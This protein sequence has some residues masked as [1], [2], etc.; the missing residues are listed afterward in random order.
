MA[1][2]FHVDGFKKEDRQVY[3][4]KYSITQPTDEEGQITGS[5][6]GG[7]LTVRV[8]SADDDNPELFNWMVQRA[9]KAN[10]SVKFEKDTGEAGDQ[11]VISFENA[12]CV[13]YT[14][15]FEKG[16]KEA[17]YEEVV[18]SCELI[19]IGTAEYKSDWAR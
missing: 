9:L 14:E 11:R 2:I 1:V 3:T 17:H 4:F 8:K 15:G 7:F 16:G 10:G 12:I 18:L 19:K 13:G 5:P 6:V